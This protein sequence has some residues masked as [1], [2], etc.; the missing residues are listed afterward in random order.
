MK[1]NFFSAL[2]AM[3]L[4]VAL[5]ACSGSED[6]KGPKLDAEIKVNTRSTVNIPLLNNSSYNLNLDFGTSVR[7]ESSPSV[8]IKQDGKW[9]NCGY[10]KIKPTDSG[11]TFMLNYATK[12]I[13][14][15]QP[16]KLYFSRVET[17]T[18]EDRLYYK[19]KLMRND[20]FY[21]VGCGDVNG[22]SSTVKG[23]IQ[24]ACEVVYVTNATDK[25]IEF[26]LLGYE[27][28]RLWYCHSAFLDFESNASAERVAVTQEPEC[29]PITVELL[30]DN[31][32]GRFVS[33]FPPS[34]Y[35]VN[36]ARMI[37]EIDGVKVK[38]RNTISSDVEIAHQNSYAFVVQ[39]DGTNLT[40]LSFD[41]YEN[42]KIQEVVGEE[43]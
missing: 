31:M 34:G 2:W 12:K 4:C 15:S 36:K 14:K 41:R 40:I 24:G 26:K 16:Y 21:I 10:G 33:Y 17:K 30:S 43:L 39:W 38:S 3:G 25:P 32:W 13:K 35:K 1:V 37:A 22:A 19:S 18:I 7:N 28:D 5:C 20:G 9:F 6:D 11:S 42:N 29:E 8:F 23:M 27:A